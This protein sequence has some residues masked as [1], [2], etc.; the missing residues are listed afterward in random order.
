MDKKELVRKN[1]RETLLII[2]GL[3]VAVPLVILL[4]A[5]LGKGSGYLE[6]PYS[7]T[8]YILDDSI[9]MVLYGR[10]ARVVEDAADAAF[11]EVR[12]LDGVFNR[13]DPASE[14]AA[15]NRDAHAAPVRV[16]DDLFA[17][18]AL[19]K[20]F[21]AETGG[22]FDVTLGPVIDLWDVVGRRERGLGP[23]SDAEIEEALSRC[24]DEYMVLNEADRT[25]YLAKEGMIIDLGGVAKGYA[26]D[27]AVKVLKQE[28]ITSGFVDMVSTTLTIGEKPREA[29]GPDWRIA[30]IN[31]RDPGSYLG[32]LTLE[33]DTCLSSSGDYQRYFEYGG[34]RYHHIFDPSTG[35]PA[36]A[37]ISDSVLIPSSSETGGAETD[38]LSTALFVMGYPQAVEWAE[39]HGYELLIVDAQGAAHTTPGMDAH[40]QLYATRI[41]L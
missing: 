27:L 31:A 7:R 20:R 16:S 41:D 11:A 26:A 14:L 40:L 25:V 12:R 32:Q 4:F 35:R 18:L 21:H 30:V 3:L 28:G 17:V 2:V 29:G 10:D 13:H 39:G 36:T 23:P 19:S 1:R 34:V 8:E 9:K 38:I 15:V 6:E 24:G 33:G 37:S 22:S 5:W